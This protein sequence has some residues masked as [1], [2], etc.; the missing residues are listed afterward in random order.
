MKTYL[1][2][3]GGKTDF[4]EG[5]EA[6]AA[7]LLHGWS[8]DL[9]AQVFFALEFLIV[10]LSLIQRTDLKKLKKITENKR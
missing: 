6:G 3:H 2:V 8:C 7:P 10:T 5:Q 4:W 1:P 9:T